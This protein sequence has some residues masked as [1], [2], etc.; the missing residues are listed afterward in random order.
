MEAPSW[1]VLAFT[2]L[3]SIALFHYL[4]TTLHRR[5]RKQKYPPG[6]KPWPIIGN[7]NLVGSNP[8]QSFHHLSKKYGDI[9][10]LK[11]GSFPVVV[12]S[13]PEMAREILQTHGETFASRPA[14]AAG[15]YTSYNYSDMTWLLTEIT[16]V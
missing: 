16:G 8:H 14:T 6:P 11:F 3:A 2:W 10:Q 5:L 13:S 12:V 1:A 4:T 9:M 7:L 15:K